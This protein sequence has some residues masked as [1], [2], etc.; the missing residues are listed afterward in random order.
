MTYYLIL[1]IILLIFTTCYNINKDLYEMKNRIKA[2][3]TSAILLFS[4]T[5]SAQLSEQQ[6]TP[7]IKNITI[8][9]NENEGSWWGFYKGG[10]ASGSVKTL[11][12]GSNFDL[13]FPYI[14]G[15]K[16]PVK[17]D[18]LRNKVIKAV[19]FA[20]VHT[21]FIDDVSVWISHKLPDTPQDADICY[22]PVDMKDIKSLSSDKAANVVYL[23]EAYTI[24]NEDV[25]VGYS[26]K[27][28]S[29]ENDL[30]TYPLLCS[31]DATDIYAFYLNNGLGEWLDFSESKYGN[32]AFDILLEEDKNIIS[33]D[34]NYDKLVNVT[35]VSFTLNYILNGENKD[36]NFKAADI[37]ADNVINIVDVESIIDLILELYK[38]PADNVADGQ[39]DA[40]MTERN[41][42]GLGVSVSGNDAYRGFQMDVVVPEGGKITSVVADNS[43]S[44]THNV[45]FSRLSDGR[46]RIIAH[47]LNGCCMAENGDKLIDICADTDNIRIENI[48]FVTPELQEKRFN[49][50]E[51]NTAGID[52]INIGGADGDIYGISGVRTQYPAKGIYIVNGKKII[53]K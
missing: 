7:Q 42:E 16:L 9:A 41:N 2:L 4:V 47:S 8:N 48:I 5:A 1:I 29:F 6:I 14:C 52:D 22:M 21:D 15:I 46:Y 11:G 37:N 38:A 53:I 50:V 23:P 3:A 35:D 33:G 10:F 13:P 18:E 26:F 30:C 49:S 25:Y 31:G 39:G 44:A 19:R 27:V 45:M 32:L 34:A 24:Y 28:T 20:F 43:I 36:F 12:M 51:G 17:N 40:V